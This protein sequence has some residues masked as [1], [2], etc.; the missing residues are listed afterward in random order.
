V[1]LIQPVC[2][3]TCLPYVGQHVCAMLHDGTQ[4]QGVISKVTDH[5]L[6]FNGPLQSAEVMSKNPSKAKKQLQTMKQKGKSRTQTHVQTS[7]YGPGPYGTQTP[8]GPPYG[9]AAPYAYPPYGYGGV[10]G[11]E[12][13]AIAL[14]FLIPFLFI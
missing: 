13:A 10:Y 12:W 8:Y 5:G 14:L 6:E 7:A 4:V 9:G 11:L 3:E 1:Q 2:K